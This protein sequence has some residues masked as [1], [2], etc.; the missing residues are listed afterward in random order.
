M[1]HDN[2]ESEKFDVAMN[3]LL[4]ANPSAVKAAMEQEKRE[5]EAERKVK[6]ASSAPASPNRNT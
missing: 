2:T 6:R 5:R 3:K 1:S 4:K